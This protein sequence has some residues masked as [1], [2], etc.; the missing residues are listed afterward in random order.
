MN[1]SALHL[2][3]ALLVATMPLAHAADAARQGEVATRGA[4]VM[5]FSLKATQHIFTKT[6]S[7]GTQTVVARNRA[8][9]EQVRLVREHLRQIQGEFRRGD[10]AGPSHIHGEDMPGLAQLKAAPA[11]AI[12]ISYRNVPGGAQLS[13]RTRRPELVSALHEWFDA[14]LSDHGPDAMAGH[15]HHHAGMHGN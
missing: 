14:Q 3:L 12:G 5:P 8:D 10:F 6:G 7:G 4:D 13:Y 1:R 15:E 2:A 9:R 11:G